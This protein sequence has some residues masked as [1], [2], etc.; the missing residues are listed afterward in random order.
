MRQEIYTSRD[1]STILHIYKFFKSYSYLF[2]FIFRHA[3]VD[4]HSESQRI[5]YKSG[6]SSSSLEVPG[7]KFRQSGFAASPFPAEPSQPAL[8]I[9]F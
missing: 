5:A 1:I 2:I 6:F 9:I 7:I 3:C 8:Q 4:K